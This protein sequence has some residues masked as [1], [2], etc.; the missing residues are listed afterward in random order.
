MNNAAAIQAQLVDIRNLGTEKCV[1]LTLH[2]PAEQ[3]PLVLKA[4]GWPTAVEPVPVALARLTQ[5]KEAEAQPRPPVTESPSATTGG[6]QS[7]KSWHEMS[8]SQQAGLL[9]GEISFATFLKD[10]HPSTWRETEGTEGLLKDRAA[11]CVRFLCGV[12]SRS[13]IK[14]DTSAGGYWIKLNSEYRAWMQQPAVVG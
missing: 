1:K 11:Q 5:P 4:F 6:A 13:E 12:E 8:M 3:A 2:I 9:C 14:P 7:K 10:Y